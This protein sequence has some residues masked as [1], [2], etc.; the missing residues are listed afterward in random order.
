MSCSALFDVTVIFV[1]GGPGAGK[2]TQCAKLLQTLRCRHL[3]VGDLLRAE[4]GDPDSQYGRIIAR[5][6]QEGRIGP[7]EITTELLRKAIETSQ[8]KNAINVFLIDGSSPSST[9]LV[10]T[11]E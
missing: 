1:L 6:M 9:L 11:R 8:A 2:G 7:A 10:S 5:N 4:K 3:S